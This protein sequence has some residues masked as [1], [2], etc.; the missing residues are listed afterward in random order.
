MLKIIIPGSEIVFPMIYKA[1]AIMLPQG[2]TQPYGSAQKP[3][4]IK[5]RQRTEKDNTGVNIIF[6]QFGFRNFFIF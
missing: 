1:C 5:K 3:L 4:H 2:A 6:I